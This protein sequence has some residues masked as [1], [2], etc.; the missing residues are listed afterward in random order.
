MCNCSSK[1]Q[2]PYIPP[3]IPNQQQISNCTYTQS[4]LENWLTKLD[5]VESMN[6]YSQVGLTQQSINV[7]KGTIISA[8]SNS[9]N[10]CYFSTSLDSINNIIIRIVGNTSC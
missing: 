3:T 4:Q 8:L 6:Y 1:V 2:N 10:I 7:Y 5:C 9:N